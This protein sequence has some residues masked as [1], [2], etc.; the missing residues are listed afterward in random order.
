MHVIGLDFGGSAVKGA[1]LNQFGERLERFSLP[2]R[3][4]TLEL[5]FESFDQYVQSLSERYP[6]RGIAI[7]ACGAVDVERG[8]V[9]GATLL[10]YIHGV[11]LKQAFVE[12]YDLPVE[13][14]NDACCAALAES[15][16]GD[17]AQSE[18]FCLVVIGSGVGGA[19]VSQGEIQ[20]G[21]HLYGGEFGYS[22]L[23]FSDGQPK[24]WSELG[25]TRA[26]VMQAAK[27]LQMPRSELNGLK[28]FQMYDEQHPVVVQVV[29]QW[30]EYL[31]QGLFNVQYTVDPECLILGGAISQRADLIAL[32]QRKFEQLS[33]KMPYCHIWPNVVA[34]KFGNDANLIG[35]LVHFKRRQSITA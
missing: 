2:S 22:I 9:H 26:L 3:V 17:F 11:E 23:H 14:E 27:A 35:A 13:I 6:I 24:V 30:L 4:N 18:L 29:E 31:A 28:V 12:R 5:W 10:P 1:V 25:S 20:K 19:I 8:I 32:L 21:H 15:E 16:L 33:E 34:S 7:S